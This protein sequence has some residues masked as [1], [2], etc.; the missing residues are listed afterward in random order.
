MLARL[1]HRQ[2]SCLLSEFKLPHAWQRVLVAVLSIQSELGLAGGAARVELGGMATALPM[3][4]AVC[5]MQNMS[6]HSVCERELSTLLCTQACHTCQL[7]VDD[8]AHHSAAESVACDIS[9]RDL[10]ASWHSTMHD[11]SCRQ[12]CRQA[13]HFFFKSPYTPHI[14]RPPEQPAQRARDR[15]AKPH[16]RRLPL[17]A[18]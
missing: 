18:V 4:H 11:P 8:I 7:H 10:T 15:T 12:A 13:R 5:S 16:K 3:W 17:T 2:C 6:R 1:T 9:F 14:R